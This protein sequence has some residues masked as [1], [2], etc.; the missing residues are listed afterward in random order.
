MPI[1]KVTGVEINKKLKQ[2]IFHADVLDQMAHNND[3]RS[4]DHARR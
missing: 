1:S 3:G 2:T 4:R